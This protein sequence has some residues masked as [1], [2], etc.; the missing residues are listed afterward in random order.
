MI[1][2]RNGMTMTEWRAYS[3]GRFLGLALMADSMSERDLRDT[4]E[5]IRE[6]YLREENHTPRS[7]NTDKS[8]TTTE[9]SNDE[10]N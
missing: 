6:E 5:V 4:L 2:A 7:M 3:L 9:G 1:Y 10:A 8:K